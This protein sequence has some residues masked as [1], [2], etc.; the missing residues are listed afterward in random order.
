MTH[1]P[2]NDGTT[3]DGASPAKP[4]RRR[5]RALLWCFALAGAAGCAV[6]GLLLYQG[7]EREMALRVALSTSE[8][9]RADT[10]TSLDRTL[11][12]LQIATT[13]R[14]NVRATLQRVEAERV[15]VLSKLQATSAALRSVTDERD[16]VANALRQ[17][18]A[19]RAS[20]ESSLN[21]TR[22][23]LRS[24]ITER[25]GLRSTLRQTELA[26][27]DATR[28]F[29]A[30]RDQVYEFSE[31]LEKAASIARSHRDKLDEIASAIQ[32]GI[33]GVADIPGEE[34]VFSGGY[35]LESEY[36]KVVKDYNNLVDRFSAAVE[37]SN[38]L[39]EIVNRVI[40]ILRS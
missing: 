37:R 29:S 21:S 26:R 23:T 18:E 36:R 1:D 24:V 19:E 5:G 13:E 31:A 40:S 7:H 12:A 6:Q 39:G 4:P 34:F 14:D 15:E 28:A 3:L 33:I 17:S 22:G 27:D 20:A 2:I 8:S 10:Q 35:D 16:Q 11:A 38:D 25:D 32:S 9:E 30:A